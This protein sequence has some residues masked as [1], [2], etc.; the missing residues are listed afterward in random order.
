MTDTAKEP[1]DDSKEELTEAELNQV[2]GG[3]CAGMAV[4]KKH[5]EPE[6]SP[7]PQLVDRHVGAT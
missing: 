2:A 6:K 4:A 5:T 3:L 1:I 7:Q